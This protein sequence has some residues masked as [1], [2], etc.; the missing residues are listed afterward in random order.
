MKIGERLQSLRIKKGISGNHLAKLSGIS[1]S[2]VSQV[3]MNAKSPTIRTLGMM[4]DALDI[5]IED[6]FVVKEPEIPNKHK[7][8]YKAIMALTP[9]QQE[10]LIRII[11]HIG[12]VQNFL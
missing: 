2:T 8:L 4:C 5:T 1:Q 10:A 3:E 6:F 12:S 9:R 7:D 11:K